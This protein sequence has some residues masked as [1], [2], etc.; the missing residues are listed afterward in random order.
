[1]LLK[2]EK[3]GEAEHSPRYPVTQRDNMYKKI[4]VAPVILYALYYNFRFNWNSTTPFIVLFR[5]DSKV[6]LM[7][8]LLLRGQKIVFSLTILFSVRQACNLYNSGNEGNESKTYE[9]D[10]FVLIVCVKAAY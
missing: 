2:N 6:P 7:R 9:K 1:M 4:R 5:T 3:D 10:N 8:S